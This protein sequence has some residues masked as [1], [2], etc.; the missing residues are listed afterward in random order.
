MLIVLEE[1]KVT[2]WPTVWHTRQTHTHT[3]PFLSLFEI[4]EWGAKP[5]SFIIFCDN[6]GWEKKLVIGNPQIIS[7]PYVSHYFGTFHKEVL[8]SKGVS[9][10]LPWSKKTQEPKQFTNWIISSR[11]RVKY[12][13]N[14]RFISPKSRISGIRKDWMALGYFYI[15]FSFSVPFLHCFH[16]QPSAF[17]SHQWPLLGT[18]CGWPHRPALPGKS[19]FHP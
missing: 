3:H 11:W 13:I 19:L 12:I 8:M 6:R 5:S 2:L 17:M 18:H 7:S 9:K 16:Q 1:Y 10:N 4:G 15:R 14:G